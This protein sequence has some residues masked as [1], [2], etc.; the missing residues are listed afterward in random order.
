[1]RNMRR[2]FGR[3][4]LMKKEVN[5]LRGIFTRIEGSGD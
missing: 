5:M 3:T 2:I 4:G 1:M